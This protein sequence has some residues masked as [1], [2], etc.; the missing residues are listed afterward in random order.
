M[1]LDEIDR[2]I[3]RALQR[4][5][6]LAIERVAEEA[7][8]TKTPCWRR[9]KRLEAEGVIA[10]RVALLDPRRL[11]LGVTVYVSV[12]AGRH[13]P[14]WLERFARAVAAIPEIVEAYRMSGETDYLLRVVAPDIAG[15]DRV[16]KRLIASVDLADVSSAFAMEELK[17]TTELPLEAGG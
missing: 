3:L 13:E 4:D 10:R 6:G 14:A 8:L 5:A 15:Y 17:R 12:R 16:Y 1:Q 2:K 7:G 9:I 11:G